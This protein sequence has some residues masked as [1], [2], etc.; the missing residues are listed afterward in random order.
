[1][2]TTTFRPMTVKQAAFLKTLV[3]ERVSADDQITQAVVTDARARAVAGTFSSKEASAL[4]EAL[5]NMP[6]V[7]GQTATSENDPEPGVYAKDGN[8]FHV[9]VSTK[10]S[11][12][13][14]M[15]W[16]GESRQWTYRGRKGLSG[17]NAR[18]TAATAAAF[19]HAYGVCVFCTRELTD[20]RSVVVGYGPVC[21]KHNSLPWGERPTADEGEADVDEAYAHLGLGEPPPRRDD[22]GNKAEREAALD[23]FND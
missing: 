16:D 10:T 15:E 2:T 5:K 21:A 23:P 9:K 14:A 19:G 3:S 17:L 1:M 7:E 8:L 20:E 12:A 22:E 11:K 18:I 13:Y 4:I 6:K